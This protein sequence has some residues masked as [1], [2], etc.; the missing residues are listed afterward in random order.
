M[1]IFYHFYRISFVFNILII[2]CPPGFFGVLSWLTAH[3]SYLV[4]CNN[5]LKSTHCIFPYV[6]EK[7]DIKDTVTCVPTAFP[8]HADAANRK[9]AAVADVEGAFHPDGG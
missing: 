9:A 1:E 4:L 7:R 8:A 6:P 5:N 3:K 2:F